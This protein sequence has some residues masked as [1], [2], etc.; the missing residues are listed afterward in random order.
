M[1][2]ERNLLLVSF[3]KFRTPPRYYNS[4]DFFLKLLVI[5][6]FLQAKQTYMICGSRL[7]SNFSNLVCSSYKVVWSYY[8]ELAMEI[9]AS[10]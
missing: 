8:R 9:L 2:N 6:S 10:N 4:I 1:Q 5:L 7:N 3:Y